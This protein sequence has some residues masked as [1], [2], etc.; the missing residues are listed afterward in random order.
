MFDVDANLEADDMVGLGPSAPRCSSCDKPITTSNSS[1][2]TPV[3][4]INARDDSG[5]DWTADAWIRSGLPRKRRNM[6]SN[7]GAPSNVVIAPVGTVM[8]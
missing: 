7:S 5:A 8:P 2:Q 6:T 3:V 1:T 4:R